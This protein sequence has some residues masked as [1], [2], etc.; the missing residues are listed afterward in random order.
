MDLKN[1]RAVILENQYGHKLNL[2]NHAVIKFQ[3]LYKYKNNIPSFQSLE[4]ERRRAFEDAIIQ[5]YAVL[6]EQRFGEPFIYP[7]DD[8]GRAR[9]SAIIEIAA[10]KLE[11]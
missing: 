4:G 1:E 9:L 5:K 2:R 11:E 6:Y 10:K 3:K 8:L 7:S